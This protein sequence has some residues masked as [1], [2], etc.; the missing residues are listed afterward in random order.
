MVPE[1]ATGPFALFNVS[2][3]VSDSDL[4]AEDLLF[5]LPVLRLLGLLRKKLLEEHRD[6]FDRF[7]CL[8]I[9]RS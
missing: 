4:A 9:P 1:L 8:P 6:P 5:C 7:D 2:Y 3:L